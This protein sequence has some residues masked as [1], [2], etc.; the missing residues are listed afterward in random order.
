MTDQTDTGLIGQ[1]S[2]ER[3][4]LGCLLRSPRQVALDTAE[5]LRAD[6]L[7]DPRHQAVLGAIMAVAAVDQRDPDPV[8]VEGAM[9]RHGL[10]RSLTCD[11]NAATFLADVLTSACVVESLGHYVQVVTEHTFRRRLQQAGARLQQAAAGHA[12]GDLDDLVSA[13]LEAIKD[14]RSRLDPPRPLKAVDSA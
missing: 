7:T 12:L 8:L 2:A 3:A 11:T 5:R 14:A 13:E 1:P 6:D 10:E 4:V 9:R